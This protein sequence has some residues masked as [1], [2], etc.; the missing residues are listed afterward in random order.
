MTIRNLIFEGGGVK[1]VAYL[2]ALRVL[3]EQGIL[4]G[5]DR[6]AGTSAGAITALLLGL[7]YTVDEIQHE[8]QTLDFK[9]FLDDSWGVVRDTERLLEDYGWYKGD[10]F[11]QWARDRVAQKMG[12]PDA[13]FLQC[14][15]AGLRKMFFVGANLAS[16][17][18]EVYSAETTWDMPVARAV[19]ISM[20]IPLFFEAVKGP[21]YNLRVDGGLLWN[22]PVQLFDNPR[23]YRR[24][25][26]LPG[27]AAWGPN[28]QT[29][30]LK[31]DSAREIARARKQNGPDLVPIND[32]FDYAKHLVATIMDMQNALHLKSHDSERTVYIDSLGVGATDFDLSDKKKAE[33]VE[34]GRKAMAAYLKLDV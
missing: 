6:V 9:R 32:F 1:G 34:S 7:G 4:A 25:E 5:I 3:D 30:G 29:L 17:E 18:V 11:L 23:Y 19:R 10:A 22:Y 20:S 21:G 16:H 33:L 28:P 12:N 15:Q 8:V 31:L 14:G 13:T 24:G 26:G 27:E 2:G